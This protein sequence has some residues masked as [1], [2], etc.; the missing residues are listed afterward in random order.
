M[1]T[2]KSSISHFLFHEIEVGAIWL[3]AIPGFVL[4]QMNFS[5]HL[6]FLFLYSLGKDT[7]ILR[8]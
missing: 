3:I 7:K 8:D 2:F 6:S 1:C 4:H 5:F